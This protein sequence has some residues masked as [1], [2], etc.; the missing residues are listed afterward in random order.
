MAMGRAWQIIYGRKGNA[1]IVRRKIDPQHSKY[2]SRLSRFKNSKELLPPPVGFFFI[3][4]LTYY[5]AFKRIPSPDTPHPSLSLPLKHHRF[6][7]LPT[8]LL[9][10]DTSV[11]PHGCASQCQQLVTAASRADDRFS[12][13]GIRQT[14]SEESAGG[15]V[16]SSTAAGHVYTR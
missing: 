4:A 6:S 12:P 9:S 13:T 11:L 3:I 10:A 15:R 2:L 8:D 16:K 7:F 14:V 1:D 5:R